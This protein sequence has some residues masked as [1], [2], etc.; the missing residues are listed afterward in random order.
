MK[1]SRQAGQGKIG[2]IIWLLAALA[3][4]AIIWNAVPVKIKTAEFDS[5]MVEQAKFAGRASPEKLRK[6]ILDRAAEVDIPLDPKNLVVKK[7]GGRVRITCF[8][9]I[10]V[11]FPL[12]TYNW[13]VEHNID[14]PVFVI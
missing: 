5:Y 3:V 4:G 7:V 9:T 2:C 13:K 1:S 6:R 12:Y 11:E 10:P 8:Y 14:R